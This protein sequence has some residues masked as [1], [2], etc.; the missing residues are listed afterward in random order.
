MSRSTGKRHIVRAALESIAYQVK[1]V[2]QLMQS[3]SN[4]RIKIVRVDGGA[5][6]NRFLMQYQAD[7]LDIDVIAS[8][9]VELSSMGS[10]YL[11]GLG[12]G[13]WKTTDEIYD[14]NQEN[15]LYQPLITNDIRDKYYQ[16]WMQSVNSVL[17][18]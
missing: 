18:C 17:V 13:I 4:I 3:E 7:M 9:I 1:D 12:V 15:E 8:K 16:G 2:I 11:A 5:T 6:S 14:L 10:I